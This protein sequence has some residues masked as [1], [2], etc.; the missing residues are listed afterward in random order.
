MGGNVSTR[1]IFRSFII[2][3]KIDRFY[4]IKIKNI[5]T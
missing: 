3:I 4:Y 2:E 5:N 1:E